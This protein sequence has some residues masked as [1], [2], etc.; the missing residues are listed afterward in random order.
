MGNGWKMALAGGLT[1]FG[2]GLTSLAQQRRAEAQE[3]LRQEQRQAERLQDREWAVEDRDVNNAAIAARTRRSGSSAGSSAGSIGAD[4]DGN[5]TL[6]K[7]APAAVRA[8]W[9]QAQAEA[10]A[11]GDEAPTWEDISK[12]YNSKENPGMSAG[13]TERLVQN[14]ADSLLDRPGNRKMTVEEAYRDARKFYGVGTDEPAG[15]TGGGMVPKDTPGAAAPAA[16]PAEEYPPVKRGAEHE[17]GQIYR[18]PNGDLVKY[19]GPNKWMR[20]DG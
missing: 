9:A 15:D 20:V 16:A 3:K 14:Y 7:N 2:E 4:A 8:V 18:A 5:P 12:I 10:R 17:I 11:R 1:G 19:M 13:E 6:D